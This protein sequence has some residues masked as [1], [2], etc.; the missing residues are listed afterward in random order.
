MKKYEDTCYEII[1]IKRE[2]A[3]IIHIIK[4]V[5]QCH[6]TLSHY[7]PVTA[8][9]TVTLYIVFTLIIYIIYLLTY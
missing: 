4:I 1:Q 5:S 2:S 6:F 8:C 3:P 7:Y 9:H